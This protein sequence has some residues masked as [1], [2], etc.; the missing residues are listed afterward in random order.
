[1]SA[2]HWPSVAEVTPP[3]SLNTA[4]SAQQLL[5]RD[6]VLTN[7]A[8]KHFDAN[9][10]ILLQPNEAEAAA[11]EFRRIADSDGDGRVTQQEYRAARETILA[12][13]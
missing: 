6:W 8:L 7:W 3:A 12:R 9:H 2:V 4:A 5:D 10:D 11:E 13:D 1:M